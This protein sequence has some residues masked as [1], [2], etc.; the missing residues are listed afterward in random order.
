MRILQVCVDLI[1]LSVIYHDWNDCWAEPF[2]IAVLSGR[3]HNGWLEAY[4]MHSDE[5]SQYSDGDSAWISKKSPVFA[6]FVLRSSVVPFLSTYSFFTCSHMYLCI[7][8]PGASC[9]CFMQ[10]LLIHL[11]I[12][13]IYKMISA[14][15]KKWLTIWSVSCVCIYWMNCWK[16]KYLPFA[17]CFYTSIMCTV[18]YSTVISSPILYASGNGI[19]QEKILF[20]N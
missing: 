3:Q 18:M 14:W 2:H 1:C 6:L 8:T 9:I 12:T 20:W 19:L 13:S 15:K 5:L 7:K 17:L 16:V 4:I 11:Q 10:M